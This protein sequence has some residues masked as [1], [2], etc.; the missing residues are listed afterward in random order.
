MADL[1]TLTYAVDG[2]IARLTLNRP[3]RVSAP[4]STP[5]CTRSRCRATAAASAAARI[6]SPRPSRSG[7]KEAVRERD[8]PFGDFGR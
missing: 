5:P 1:E 2:R 7:F 8:E 4:T 6:S 3:E